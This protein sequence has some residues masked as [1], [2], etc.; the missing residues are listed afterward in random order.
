MSSRDINYRK[1]KHY[2]FYCAV[3]LVFIAFIAEGVSNLSNVSKV[4]KYAA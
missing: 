2:I 3:Y 4:Y 1:K